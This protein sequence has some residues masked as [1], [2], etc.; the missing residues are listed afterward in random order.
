MTLDGYRT[1]SDEE[2][3][4]DYIDTKRNQLKIYELPLW[5]NTSIHLRTI[6]ELE[7]ALYIVRHINEIKPYQFPEKKNFFKEDK[8]W[9]SN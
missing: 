8:S 4:W 2:L 7:N 1:L 3:I 9:V 5:N 6:R